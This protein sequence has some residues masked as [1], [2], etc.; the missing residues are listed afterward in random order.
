MAILPIKSKNGKT[1][2]VEQGDSLYIERLRH[3]QYQ[4]TNW[5]F[6]QSLI[7]NWT[8]AIDIGSNNACNAIHYSERFEYV[9]CFEPTLLAQELW[10]NTIRDNGVD[11][12]QL[13]TQALGEYKA[14]SEIVL[15]PKN[16]GHNHII[17]KNRE[18]KNG[19]QTVEIEPLD[20]FAFQQVGFIKIDVEGFEF[21]VLKGSIDTVMRNRPVLQLEIVERQCRAFGYTDVELVDWIRDQFDYEVVS[22]V[23]GR[24]QGKFTR[25]KGEMDL[26]FQ[27]R[28]QYQTTAFDTLFEEIG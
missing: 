16:G 3:G 11:N 12:C 21:S 26:F 13:H 18:Y 22:K 1:Y 8:R 25:I 19:T 17:N 14:V 20:S 4:S 24:L 15:H 27:P 23:R 2:W 6:A 10:Y 28:E 5:A 9:E 7:T